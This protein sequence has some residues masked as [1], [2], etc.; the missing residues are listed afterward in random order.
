[1]CTLSWFIRDCHKVRKWFRQAFAFLNVCTF[2]HLCYLILT[3]VSRRL[4][5]FH[6]VELIWLFIGSINFISSLKIWLTKT[7]SQLQLQKDET[8]EVKWCRGC[9]Y[10]LIITDVFIINIIKSI[11]SQRRSRTWLAFKT[12]FHKVMKHVKNKWL[13]LHI[14]KSWYVGMRWLCI[15]RRETRKINYFTNNNRKILSTRFC[16]V[17]YMY[18]I[19]ILS[20]F[21]V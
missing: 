18:N 1:M 2:L 20:S 15:L 13:S 12:Y 19:M 9:V 4:S 14:Y 5:P 17:C 8:W 6:H 11:Q 7:A 3:G 21:F 10:P 16:E